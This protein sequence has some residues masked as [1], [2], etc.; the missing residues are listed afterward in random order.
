MEA[1]ETAAFGRARHRRPLPRGAGP[2]R[3]LAKREVQQPSL[4][5][6]LAAARARA[7]RARR[8]RDQRAA[9]CAR[10]A[11][12]GGRRDG[13]HR[14]QRG[15]A[16]SGPQRAEL[17]RAACR[18]RDGAARRHQGRGGRQLAARGRPQHAGRQ[19]LAP[20]W[21]TADNLDDVLGIVHLKD[22]LPFW[23]D[24]D[25]LH[26]RAGHAA[27]AGGARLRCG[28]STCC[29]RCARRASGWRSSSTSSAVRTVWSRSRIWS[30]RSW[31]SSTTST[32]AS[33]SR[34]WSRTPT[35]RSTPTAGI[36]LEELEE[37]LGVELLDGDDRDEADTLGGLI[38][39]LVDRVPTRGEIVGPSE[40]PRVRGAGCRPAPHQA[41]ADPPRPG[42]GDTAET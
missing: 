41:R 40:R 4:L 10:G 11:D 2:V 3:Q 42:T 26:A 13:R 7:G 22:L 6:S 25:T 28:C 8:D 20:R 36:Y 12:H 24:G 38:F 18:R 1:R 31:A 19:P 17:R 23:G 16:R 33:A 21:S 34:S 27:A 32:T 9:R 29:S 30:R 39:T 37:K 5:E 35:A 14:V 15:G